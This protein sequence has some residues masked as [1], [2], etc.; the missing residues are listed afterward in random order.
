MCMYTRLHACKYTYGVATISRLLKIIGLFGKISFLLQ[1][2]FAK[3][4][5]NFK[6]PTACSHPK[7]DKHNPTICMC[8]RV[9]VRARALARVCIYVHDFA[10]TDTCVHSFTL[11]LAH[12]NT[13]THTS[14][15]THIRV[16]ERL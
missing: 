6:K 10:E 2:S 7:T 1:G 8:V 9:R 16:G 15:C 5:Y 11:T 13:R 4:T 12:T 3:G 14:T